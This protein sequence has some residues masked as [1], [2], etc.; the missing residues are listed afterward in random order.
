[1]TG[2]RPPDAGTAELQR[3]L[4]ELAVPLLHRV[5]TPKRFAQL[6]R[7]AFVNAEATTARFSTGRINYS[8]I[9]ARTGLPRAEVKRLLSRNAK[10]PEGHYSNRTPAERVVRGWLTDK[11]FISKAGQPKRLNIDGGRDS[12]RRLVREYAGDVSQRAVLDELLRTKAIRRNGTQLQLRNSQGLN[13]SRGGDAL[14]RVMPIL[15]DGLRIA[16]TEPSIPID[17]YLYRL[18][19]AA[20]TV[21]DLT[22]VRNRCLSSI[23]SLLYGLRES[24]GKRKGV[25]ARM[26][27]AKRTLTVTVLLSE[28]RPQS[29][30]QIPDKRPATKRNHRE[31]RGSETRR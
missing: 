3:L 20:G 16:S 15:I 26:R 23:R 30:Y 10:K 2:V 12:F 5:I 17:S 29:P 22:L 8:K 28:S 1:M 9:A 24:L 21:A 4:A 13:R 18:R 27:S 25:P 7:N 31:L 6:S 19:L 14:S 11:R